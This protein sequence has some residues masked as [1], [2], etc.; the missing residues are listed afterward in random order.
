MKKCILS[1]MVLFIPVV[2]WSSEIESRYAIIQYQHYE[3]L[4]KLNNRIVLGSLSYLMGGR[5]GLTAVEELKRKIDVIVEKVE[6]ILQMYPSR[7]KFRIQLFDN[8]EDVR[9]VYFH[10]Y[11]KRV[12]FIAFYSPQDKTIYLSLKDAELIVLAHE[13]AHV[14]IDTYY[15]RATPVKV[16]EILA[17]YVT[18]YIED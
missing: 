1:I 17:D 13:I 12:D 5:R 16:H 2:C 7:V 10:Q 14:I 4:E 8:P 6:S 15:D 9:K 11:G 18:R 3:Q